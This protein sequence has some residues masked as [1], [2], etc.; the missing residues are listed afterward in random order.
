MPSRSE[1]GQGRA[2][3][4]QLTF[5]ALLGE[6]AAVGQGLGKRRREEERREE[7]KKTEKDSKRDGGRQSGDRSE[8]AVL[9]L[10]QLCTL[11]LVD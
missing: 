6:G 4:P 9:I 7:R 10:L 11:L 8:T 1:R 3:P 2:E 5:W